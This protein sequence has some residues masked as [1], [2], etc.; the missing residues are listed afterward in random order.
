MKMRYVIP[1]LFMQFG[2]LGAM[3]MLLC[4]FGGAAIMFGSFIGLVMYPHWFIIW[5][6]LA[7][8]GYKAFMAN[9]NFWWESHTGPY[10]GGIDLSFLVPPYIQDNLMDMQQGVYQPRH[11]AQV[12]VYGNPL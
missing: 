11:A 1:L 2:F 12:D 7:R 10:E 8:V 5:I 3:W 4:C 6:V 9:T